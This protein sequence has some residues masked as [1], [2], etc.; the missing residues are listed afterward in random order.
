MTSGKNLQNTEISPDVRGELSAMAEKDYG[1][2]SAKLN[3]AVPREAI[4]G[5]RLPAL[6]AYAKALRKNRPRAAEEFLAIL[7]HRYL[8]EDLL[9]AFLIEPE[10]DFCAAL[11]LTDAFLP[12][13]G[14]W[15]VC[16]SFSPKVFG[17]FPEKLYPHVLRWL[18]SDRLYTR[19]FAIKM[20]MNV[21]K[22]EY[23]SEEHLA[24]VA[25]IETGEYYLQM[26]QA[27]YFA[28]K[29]AER[30][31]TVY[32]WFSDYRLPPVV[33]RMAVRKALESYRI[34]DDLKARLRALSRS[35]ASR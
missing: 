22:N 7:P 6:R 35:P 34:S 16:D 26:M 20:L 5:V 11:A 25:G 14:N 1:D 12:Y 31:E 4:L 13:I 32:P 24:L 8:E 10:P 27:W 19:R 23:F 18:A 21:Y 9:H 28:T 33:H 17:K 3:P 15:A 29:L 2:F 30:E